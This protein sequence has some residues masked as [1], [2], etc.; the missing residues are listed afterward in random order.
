MADDDAPTVAE[1]PSARHEQPTRVSQE[2]REHS[3]AHSATAERAIKTEQLARA[4]G[5]GRLVTI[6][7]LASLGAMG[8]IARSGAITPRWLQLLMAGTLLAT[9][10]TG[11]IV[12]LRVE[13]T[14]RPQRLMRS[15]GGQLRSAKRSVNALP[16]E[17]IQKAGRVPNEDKTWS[18]HSG[19][20]MGERANSA[21]RLG[22]LASRKQS[23]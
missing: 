2:P 14:P 20:P 7:C 5:F 17:R 22:S 16:C 11:L 10:I 4:R 15:F 13:R 21:H 8:L 18:G 1:S 23:R 19:D 9:G 3:S 12:W 6:M